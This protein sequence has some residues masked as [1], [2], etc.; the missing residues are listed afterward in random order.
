MNISDIEK[1]YQELLARVRTRKPPEV[2]KRTRKT[3]SQSDKCEGGGKAAELSDQYRNGKQL[4][5]C[6]VC[7]HLGVPTKSQG[8]VAAHY[9]RASE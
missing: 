3:W 7:G 4:G 2:L 6:G 9:V 5:K 1:L 8:L